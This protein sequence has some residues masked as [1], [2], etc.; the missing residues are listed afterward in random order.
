L[1]FV[2]DSVQKFNSIEDLAHTLDSEIIEIQQNIT[3]YS[4]L[5]GQKIRSSTEVSSDDP[6]LLEL[7]EKIEG[8]EPKKKRRSKRHQKTLWFDYDDLKIFDGLGDKGEIEIYFKACE[9]LKER[10]HQTKHLRESL[11]TLMSKGLRKD[12]PLLASLQSSGEFEMVFL[13]T[14]EQKKKFKFNANYRLQA[15][16]S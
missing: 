2:A 12:L 6:D 13:K 11:G 14:A 5:I 3:Q 16:T 8:A 15:Q 1:Q 9:N 10:L 7:K 4:D